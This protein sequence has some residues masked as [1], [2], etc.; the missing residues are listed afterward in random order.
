MDIKP[1]VTAYDSLPS[2]KIP[3]W[4]GAIPEGIRVGELAQDTVAF[5]PS[6]VAKID[7][8]ASAGKLRFYKVGE[9]A[10]RAISELLR[11]DVRPAQAYRRY[12]QDGRKRES[13]KEGTLAKDRV[14]ERRHHQRICRFRFDMLLVSFL[15][16]PKPGL[17]AQVVG[18]EVEDEEDEIA[19]QQGRRPRYA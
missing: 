2:A 4:C 9:S 7:A 18:V 16:S 12:G 6:V 11:S 13:V 14:G 5:D 19:I 1:Y 15:R 8:A 10:R 17:V 3:D